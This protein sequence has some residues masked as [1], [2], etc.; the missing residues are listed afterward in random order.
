[1]RSRAGRIDAVRHLAAWA[2]ALGRGGG[3]DFKGGG[4]MEDGGQGCIRLCSHSLPVATLQE[5]FVNL[6][7]VETIANF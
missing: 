3:A 5:N 1:M 7:D 2:S 6:G 4:G